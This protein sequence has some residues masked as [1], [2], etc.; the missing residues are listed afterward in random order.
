MDKREFAILADAIRTY[1]PKENILPNKEAMALWYRELQDIPFPVAE[2]ALRKW[3]STNKW[4]PSIAELRET[5]ANVQNG[6]IPD[7]TDG[8]EQVCRAIR[9]YGY[10]DPKK[11]LDSMDHL[12]RECV[13]RLGFTNLCL[14]ENPTA[15]RANFRQC[16]EVI[17]KREQVRQQMAMPLLETISQIQTSG[18]L[19]IGNGG[20]SGA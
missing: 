3:V 7:W 16:Y 2:T 10:Y 9:K 8:W 12:T 5:A 11:A 6:D 17:A 14:S 19:R 20:D 4:S 13:K 1:Y 15:D 18:F